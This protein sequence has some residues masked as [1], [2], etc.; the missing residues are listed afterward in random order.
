MKI[1]NIS[2]NM[3]DRGMEMQKKSVFGGNLNTGAD[4][5][6]QKKQRAKEQAMKIVTDAWAGEQKIDADMEQRR[7]RIQEL[8]EEIGAC[9]KEIKW[10][11]DERMRLQ[12]A[13]GVAEDS[14]EQ[15]DLELLAKEMDSRI[16]GKQVSL[17][18]EER[19]EIA[20]IKKEG[21]TEYQSRSLELKSQAQHY[22]IQK[23]K[24]GKEIEIENAIISAT[25]I[26]RLKSNPM[27]QAQEQAD[28]VMKDAGEEIISLA[29]EAG[30]EH[31]DEKFKEQ[32]EEAKE[33]AEE[34]ELQEEKLESI[35]EQK[36]E[37][38]EKVS[39][40]ILET[41]AEL[42]D[43]DTRQAH[44][45]KELQEVVDKLKLLAEDIKGAKVDEIL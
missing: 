26:E 9:N 15:K 4:F 21:L 12:D 34:E 20:R 22:E 25:R 16:P 41:T 6:A 3:G 2:F 33:R 7:L 24:L 44:V 27:G 39:E 13:Y 43:M 35:K 11:E 40:E 8:K 23:Y 42:T 32:V 30:V 45:Q 18:K 29:F 38:L 28:A 5:L 10:Y 17:T 37:G 1:Q 19:E 14:E 36:E 31:V